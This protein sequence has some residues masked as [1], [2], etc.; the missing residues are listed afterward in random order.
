MSIIVICGTPGTGK[1]TLGDFLEQAGYE[2]IH[3]TDF[4]RNNQLYTHYD[5]DFDSYVI[6]EQEMIKR[7]LEIKERVIESGKKGGRLVVEGVGATLLPK[8]EIELC[9]ILT[10]DPAVI[11]KRLRAKKYPPLKI[12]QNIDAENLSVILGDAI[13]RYGREKC[14]QIDTTE[15]SPEELYQKV[16]KIINKREDHL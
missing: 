6:D 5:K 3:L 10:C 14:V 7:V 1:T 13:E 8:E 15:L 4:V 2:V 9:I 16:K 11:Q 12:E